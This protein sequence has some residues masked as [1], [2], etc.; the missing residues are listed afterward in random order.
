MDV[1]FRPARPADAPSIA[2]LRNA[3]ADQLTL[4]FGKGHWSGQTSERGVLT[5]LKS[6]TTIVGRVGRSIAC[7]VSLGT[8]KPWAIDPAYFTP[9]P[10]PL[11]LTGMAVATDRQGCGIGRSCLEHVIAVAMAW[12]AEAIRLDAYDAPAGAG[13]FYAKCGFEERGRVKYRATPLIYYELLLQVSGPIAPDEGHPLAKA[14][15]EAR[16]RR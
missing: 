15:R 16:R 10:R 13:G 5:S 1:T 8:R 9:S 2:A 11:Y 3:A 12:P 4:R 14:R 6:G 7:V